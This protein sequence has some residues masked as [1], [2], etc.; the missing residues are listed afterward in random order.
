MTQLDK[1]GL[2]DYSIAH[3]NNMII[4][5]ADALN[6][7]IKLEREGGRE[8]LLVWSYCIFFLNINI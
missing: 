7:V 4:Y 8:D 5:S 1:I 3:T 2:Q 6:V